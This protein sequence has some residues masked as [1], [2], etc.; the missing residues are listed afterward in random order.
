M[1][2]ATNAYGGHVHIHSSDADDKRAADRSREIHVA[3]MVGSL[4]SLL[5]RRVEEYVGRGVTRDGAELLARIDVDA[6][7]RRDVAAFGVDKSAQD[8]WRGVYSSAH[9]ELFDFHLPDTFWGAEASSESEPTMEAAIKSGCFGDLD[10][11]T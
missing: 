6:F 5:D 8:Y 2:S 11:W 1:A 4:R 10:V 9:M 7:T 3:L